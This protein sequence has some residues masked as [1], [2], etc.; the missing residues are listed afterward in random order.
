[1]KT[2]NVRIWEI[3]VNKELARSAH[4]RF[5]GWWPARASRRPSRRVPWPTTSDPTS[6]RRSNR[7]EAFDTES[8]LPE[9]M[10]ETRAGPTWLEFVESY[11]G[12]EVAWLGSQVP[13][14]H[15]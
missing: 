3:R 1:M 14:E 15:G 8:G 6:C 5:A 4:T 10:T 12:D 7:G 9:S 11:V 2:R 13:H